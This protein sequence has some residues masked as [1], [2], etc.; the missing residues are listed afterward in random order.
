MMPFNI[1]LFNFLRSERIKIM[2][3]VYPSYGI[4]II[5]H[6]CKGMTIYVSFLE[7]QV[8]GEIRGL[9]IFNDLPR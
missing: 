4:I 1:P 8:R 9:E 2:A 7:Q 6:F 5:E 3:D